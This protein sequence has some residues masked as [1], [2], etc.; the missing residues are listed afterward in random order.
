MKEKNKRSTGLDWLVVILF[1]CG[2]ALIAAGLW[3]VSRPL[4]MIFLG[5]VALYLAA[6]INNAANSPERTDK[7]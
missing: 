3:Q 6:C 2:V 5:L 1:F 7:K 4:A